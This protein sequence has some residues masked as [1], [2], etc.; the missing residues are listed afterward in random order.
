MTSS[1]TTTTT[2]SARSREMPT[3]E[4]PKTTEMDI[5]KHLKWVSVRTRETLKRLK[6][7]G[8]GQW[9]LLWVSGARQWVLGSSKAVNAICLA[10][11]D[12]V[13]FCS[14]SQMAEFTLRPRLIA[15]RWRR[16]SLARA[17]A[18]RLG[19]AASQFRLL[20]VGW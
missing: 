4:T 3:K 19:Q 12:P 1:L 13:T 15:H 7:A 18:I 5:Q 11:F 10:V 8:V 17:A 20:Q 9:W 16:W 14:L 6:S 2:T